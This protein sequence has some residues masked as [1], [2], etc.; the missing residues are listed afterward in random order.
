MTLCL[1]RRR[2]RKHALFRQ[3]GGTFGFALAVVFFLTVAVELVLR[4]TAAFAV[5]FFAA[6]FGAA[7]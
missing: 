6:G 1:R 5:G 2:T 4:F 7:S 3:A